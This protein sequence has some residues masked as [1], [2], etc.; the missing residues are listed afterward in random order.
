VSGV[1]VF[2]DSNI[3]IYVIGQ[4]P[5]WGA[6]AA[7]RMKTLR[8]ADDTF[9]VSELVR[10]ECRVYPLSQNDQ[11]TLAQYEAFFQS[12]DMQV[13][14]ISRAVC[15]RAAEIRAKHWLRP[16]D[17]LHLAAAAEAKC[18]LFLTNDQRLSSFPDMTVEVLN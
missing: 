14:A 6:R 12:S 15:D 5:T 9:A 11:K 1:L 2:L 3:V 8:D 7:A 10:M 17:S 13:I 16:L 4:P 18:D